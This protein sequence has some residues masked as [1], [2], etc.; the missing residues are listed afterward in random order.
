MALERIF[1]GGE[2]IA[3]EARPERGRRRQRQPVPPNSG[4]RGLRLR[5]L[6]QPRALPARLR[7]A[8]ARPGRGR[9][10]CPCSSGSSS[11]PSS[12]ELLD[13][14]FQVRVAG[15]E[16]QVAAGVR[17]RSADGLRPAEQLVA[18]RRRVHR[19]GGPPGPHLLRRARARARRRRR[20]PVGLVLA[21]RR[22]PR[23]TWSDV[24]DRQIFPVLTPLAVDPGHP[25]P[26]ISNLSL[27]LAVEVRRP[28]HRRAAVRPGEGARRCC[29]ASWSCPTASA[30]SPL[31]QVIAAHLDDPVPGHDDRGAP[32][33][34]G[35]RATPT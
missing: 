12:R 13:E 23:P 32:R 26:Y 6:H 2:T 8:P 3:P 17:T 25:F 16:D 20:P 4:H 24:F 10:R 30:S 1:T 35:S 7:R 34:S 9:G 5:A 29:P 15:L 27:N 11:W 18:I 21:R 14:F 33:P 19:A 28:G 31:E 22:G